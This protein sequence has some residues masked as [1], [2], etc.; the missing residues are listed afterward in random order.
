MAQ[1][2]WTGIV[3]VFV[4][5]TYLLNFTDYQV[6]T[7]IVTDRSGLAGGETLVFS[8]TV[9]MLPG[10]KA[11]LNPLISANYDIMGNELDWLKIGF[12]VGGNVK[13]NPRGLIHLALLVEMD[14]NTPALS[15]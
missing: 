12:C 13:E 5:K 1:G 10:A 9:R 2:L 8:I 3:F 14:A 4:S 11:F 7:I 15:L 6:D